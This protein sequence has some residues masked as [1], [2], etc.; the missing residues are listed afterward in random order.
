MVIKTMWSECKDKQMPQ[1]N[2]IEGPPNKI[3]I[4]SQLIFDLSISNM[5]GQIAL[6]T[7]SFTLV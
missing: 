3:N 2:E 1:W 7:L 6:Q 4:Y 5:H